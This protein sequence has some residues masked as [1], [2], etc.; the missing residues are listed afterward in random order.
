MRPSMCHP[1]SP[2]VQNLG[3][4]KALGRLIKSR[5]SPS[6]PYTGSAELPPKLVADSL[7]ECYL[8]TNETVYRVLHIPTFR[9]EYESF[10]TT[11]A[12]GSD[13]PAF[14][15]L[16][17]L[18]LALGALTYDRY[19]SWR[20]SAI[21]WIYEAL[22]YVSAPKFKSRLNLRF[23]QISILLLV[24]REFVA[25]NIEAPWIAAGGLLRTAMFMG[26]HRDPGQA[27]PSSVYTV[28]MRRRIWN[29]ILEMALQ[30]SLGMG[31]P[32]LISMDDFNT[33]P[34]G[35]FDDDQLVD[36]E[37]ATPKADCEPTQMT[38]A[39][40]LRKTFASRLAVAKSLNDL[41]ATGAY[42][43]ALELDKELRAK[44]KSACEM[45]KGYR[46]CFTSTSPSA[47]FP[48]QLTDMIINRYINALHIPF[49]DQALRN[50]ARYAYSRKATVDA[51]LKIWCIAY[52]E[53][54]ITPGSPEAH[55][56][57]NSEIL[58]FVENSSGFFR[59]MTFQALLLLCVELRA[60][61]KEQQG[62]GPG[63]I[64]R[65]LLA[66]LEDGKVWSLHCVK[67]GEVNAK[68][69]FL[70][71]LLASQIDALSRGVSEEN[72]HPILQQAAEEASNLALKTL[73]EM[74]SAGLDNG[75]S[76]LPEDPDFG[77]IESV[78]GNFDFSVSQLYAI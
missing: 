73:E 40:I 69:F 13:D 41:N 25:N 10:W 74:A 54:S 15:I 62:M 14:T 23:L 24:A 46:E 18:V 1:S 6:W 78:M 21:S 57:K 53:N 60:Q 47:Y 50:D 59:K 30:A 9:R 55:D 38:A 12:T 19:C 51:A 75:D 52:P 67:A 64:R 7:V 49:F 43:E 61:I 4:C 8:T 39:L 16:L 31:G 20:A 11:D 66:V 65:D 17:R 71:C 33:E 32:P 77:D 44:Y 68:G 76:M 48:L 26:L 70:Q 35:N 28:E 42:A 58:R 27:A 72:M 3:R 22:M 34:P 2:V 29:T 36:Q 37:S 56:H 63:P 5:R 45:V